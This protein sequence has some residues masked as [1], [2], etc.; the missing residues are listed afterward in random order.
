L[1]LDPLY[2]HHR[3][4]TTGRYTREALAGFSLGPISEKQEKKIRRQEEESKGISS[5]FFHLHLVTSAA[6]E[7]GSR[8]Q[9]FSELSAPPSLCSLEEPETLDIRMYPLVVGI[10]VLLHITHRA[11]APGPSG[12]LPRQISSTTVHTLA[13]ENLPLQLVATDLRDPLP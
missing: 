7:D 3:V 10:T 12:D 4:L 8:F 1:K 6:G 13:V 5:L 9:L 2:W 11:L